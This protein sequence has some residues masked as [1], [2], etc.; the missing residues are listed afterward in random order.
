MIINRHFRLFILSL[1]LSFSLLPVGAYAQA[2]V[3]PAPEQAKAAPA[4][5]ETTTDFTTAN[6]LKT[7]HRYV[8]GNEV[9]AVQI[10]FR[11]G[12]RNI[13]ARN[14][15]IET[16][17]WEVAQLGT[18]NF[19][20]SVINRELARMGTIISSGGGYDYSVI[21]MQC[22]QKNFDRSWQLLSDMVLNP[23]FD[24]KETT[25]EREKIVNGLRQ[26]ADDP[27][28]YVST[29]SDR[30]MYAAHPYINRPYGTVESVSGLTAADL[31][32]Y[33]ATQLQT[34]RM[35]A[36][37]V[38][39]VTA[40][41]IKRKVELTFGKLPKGDYKPEPLPNF[42]RA[43]KAD[44]QVSERGV[45]TYYV[46]GVFAAPSP[47]D[48]D[49]PAIMVLTNILSQ[50]FFEEVRVRRNLSYAPYA[51]MN[52]TGANTGFIYV[53]TPKPNEAIR[54][55]YAEIERIQQNRIREKP[56]QD[57]INGFLTQYYQK[58]E[59]NSAQASRLGEYE[60]LGGGWRRALTWIEDVRKVTPDDLQRVANTYLRNF[61]FAVIGDARAF[62]RELFLSK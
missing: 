6:G 22:V 42:E 8:K 35:L 53:T 58:L 2:R 47:G 54:V 51:E 25:L 18:K 5:A 26:E 20:K 31:K 30:L 46:R 11:G 14:A 37:V 49:Y 57:I 24:E 33:H 60:L 4:A 27:D 56:L 62:D 34:S 16:L 50:Q 19:S 21:A 12:S 43:N 45:P 9:V 59:T 17:M 44:F 7:V 36:V 29:L 61:H 39:N 38:G 1:L 13:T 23:L 48:K 41:E 40:D 52:S 55:M 32:A 28:T 3:A 10:Y 15:G